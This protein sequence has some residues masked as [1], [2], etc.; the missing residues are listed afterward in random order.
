MA[1]DFTSED[2]FTGHAS[3]LFIMFSGHRDFLGY[4]W[5]A[6]YCSDKNKKEKRVD[7]AL[8]GCIVTIGYK[9]KMLARLAGEG[10][11]VIRR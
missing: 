2:L 7:F 10:C 3:N 11:I 5:N 8:G 1:E 9:I 4:N 6:R